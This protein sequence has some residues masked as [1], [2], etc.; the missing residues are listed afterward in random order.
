MSELEN[1]LFCKIVKGLIPSQKVYEDEKILAFKDISAQAPIHY[2]FIPKKHY[3]SLADVPLSEMSIMTE[4]FT[5]MRKVADQEG[6]SVGG[7]RNVINTRKQGGQTVD[8]LHVHLLG[9]RLMGGDM[10]GA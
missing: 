3:Q 10:T 6:V 2:L 5:A 7:F 8:H 1:C 9:G 4:L